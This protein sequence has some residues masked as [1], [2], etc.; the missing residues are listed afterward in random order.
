MSALT[1]FEDDDFLTAIQAAVV[2]SAYGLVTTTSAGLVG[3]TAW[4]SA[5]GN[6]P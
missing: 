1:P 4:V 6:A 3:S 2:R 5:L